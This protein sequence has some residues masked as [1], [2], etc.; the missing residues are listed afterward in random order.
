[1][2]DALNRADLLLLA[3]V[4]VPLVLALAAIKPW[5]RRR[6]DVLL[7]AAP[8][9]GLVA[10]LLVPVGQSVLVVPAPFRLTFALDGP[11]ALLL[12]GAA[13]LWLA[14][15]AYAVSYLRD[16]PAR[17]TFSVWWLLTLSGSFAVF[18]VADVASFYLAYAVV[19][20]SAYGLATHDDSV[21]ARRAGRVYLALTVLGEALLIAAF[22]ML[23]S[24]A[25]EANP[26]IRDAVAGLPASPWRGAILALLLVGFTMKMGLFPLHVWMPLA[27]AVA[28]VP[29]SAVLSG[30][31]VKAGVIG[32]IRF[33][34]EG[35]AAFAW[36]AGLMAAGLF[37][38]F[39]G[40][41]VGLTQRHPKRALAYSTVSQMGVVAVVLGAGLKAGD[42]AVP[43]LAAFYAVNHM[44]LK[45]AMFLTVGVAAA[46]PRT[47]LVPVL[48]VA[49]VLGFSLAGLPFTGGALAK[50]A[51]K[52]PVG[53]GLPGLLL[54]LSAG[55]TTVLMARYVLLLLEAGKGGARA[56]AP[57]ARGQLVPWALLSGGAVLAP[58]AL[59][60]LVAG[61]GLGAAFSVDAL[62]KGL[63]PVALGLAVAAL[64]YQRP[65]R[66][67]EVPAGDILALARP[68][69][70][71][72]ARVVD[73]A[74][75]L[76][77]VLRRWSTAALALVLLALA[78]A[79]VMADAVFAPGIGP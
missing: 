54:A 76:D 78:L 13:L 23:A 38:A 69:V 44:L 17:G 72:F 15:G 16:D 53:D 49:A 1:M 74:A 18:L 66:V 52:A 65:P 70:A 73:A 31:V 5:V 33:L 61:Q 8:L 6:A 57:V 62:I 28:P 27:H 7:L 26:L 42:A 48:V 64:L 50:Y 46:C 20:F 47:R 30:I 32:L 79:Y 75:V 39:Y 2:S 24:G 60:P 3:A 58:F 67:G 14:A 55:G 4:F 56:E 77:A 29:G 21:E 34:P 59:F 35:V 45:G 40:V 36:G 11:G 19:S 12:G 41:A 25:S 71:L 51:V 10:A 37:T 63:W 22:V 43:A 9:P 68:L